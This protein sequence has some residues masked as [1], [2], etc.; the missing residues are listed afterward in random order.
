ML[1][2]Y[3]VSNFKSIGHPIEFSM[4]PSSDTTSQFIKEIK[5]PSGTLSLLQRGCFFGP[6]ASGKTSFIES[7][8]F[9]KMFVLGGQGRVT[10]IPITQFKAELSDLDG[11]STFDFT[12]FVANEKDLNS[13][14]CDSGDLYE[15]GFS[16]NRELVKEEWLMKLGKNGD[17][18][19][20]YTRTTDLSGKTKIDIEENFASDDTD[21][22]K[23]M[24]IAEVLKD[25]V[26]KNQLFLYKLQDSGVSA[27]LPVFSWFQDLT[28]MLPQSDFQPL[29]VALPLLGQN[30]ELKDYLVSL[31][32]ALDTGVTNVNIYKEE[33]TVDEFCKA[34][35]IPPKVRAQFENSDA[36]MLEF[37]GTLFIVQSQEV[38]KIKF[39]HELNGQEVEFE[40]AEE[41]D[42]L[43][44]LFEI[45]SLF[46]SVQK[47]TNTLLLIDE[48]E[49]SLH[50]KLF[51]RLLTE[52]FKIN[53]HHC[54]LICTCNDTNLLN[55]K[56]MAVDEI[57]FIN[58]NGQGESLLK[59]LSDFEVTKNTNV[60]QNYLTGRYG[61]VPLVSE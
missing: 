19:T 25:T 10:P 49:R 41:S 8:N 42:G 7:L 29:P 26:Q 54:Q 61:F 46:F 28:V 16:L 6:N 59:P 40:F 51:Q 4:L 5:V 34:Y 48:L 36:V 60:L 20:L 32:N 45:L 35:K 47:K 18:L 3:Y 23:A 31:L 56:L 9:A 33:L 39:V 2:K 21:P 43:R 15:Y 38:W 14:S 17:F 22:S 57:W 50:T 12:L 24:R 53:S 11:L 44:R 37:S 13:E 30:P 27:V 58:K 55:T 52:F 1:V